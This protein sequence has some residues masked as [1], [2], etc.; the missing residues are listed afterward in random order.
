MWKERERKCGKNGREKA[1]MW[2]MTTNTFLSSF[3]FFHA[4]NDSHK[5]LLQNK[6]KKSIS[7]ELFC[8]EKNDEKKNDF[9]LIRRFPSGK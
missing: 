5:L 6:K 1:V 9:Q 3:L 7:K 8:F 4:G 2:P